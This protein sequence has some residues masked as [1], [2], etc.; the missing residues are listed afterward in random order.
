[1]PEKPN[2]NNE[3]N[4]MSALADPT[5]GSMVA[6]PP[7][8]SSPEAEK[9]QEPEV[10]LSKVEPEK[11]P[12]KKPAEPEPEK[13]PESKK[14][15]AAEVGKR[16]ANVLGEEDVNKAIERMGNVSKVIGDKNRELG[17]MRKEH[18][19]VISGLQQEVAELRGML[20]SVSAG[21]TDDLDK[22]L[23]TPQQ[24][25]NTPK[26]L[27]EAD[28]ERIQAKATERA[29]ARVA[30]REAGEAFDRKMA[31]KYGDIW[32]QYKPL[33]EKVAE[34]CAQNVTKVE[35]GQ[36]GPP[37][38]YWLAGIGQM[39]LD[40]LQSG[41]FGEPEKPKPSSVG[42]S[43]STSAA[44]PGKTMSDEEF[45]AEFD[46]QLRKFNDPRF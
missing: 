15:D 10:D 4:P 42:H 27:T 16:L 35:D 39:F 11:A 3:S 12:E 20:K 5:L 43:A 8:E 36:Y 19:E 18:Q 29:E 17:G 9:P 22:F 46:R 28:I 37:E 1:M 26:Y 7:P 30:E 40:R 24:K 14:L 45:A 33:G 23:D 34:T 6:Q 25:E 13:K 31:S 41:G 44:E 2:E 21:N 38:V 32:G